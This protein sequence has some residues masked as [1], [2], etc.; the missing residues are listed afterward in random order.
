M[1][2]LKPVA[3]LLAA[4]AIG[5][6]GYEKLM[7]AGRM[8]ISGTAISCRQRQV[9]DVLAKAGD[10]IWRV[11]IGGEEYENG[12]RV[13]GV[14]EHGVVFDMYAL[15]SSGMK[16]EFFRVNFDG[17]VEYRP[18]TLDGIRVEKTPAQG[19]AKVTID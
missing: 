17:K 11:N 3:L 19:I 12:I 1:R 18:S 5:F 2:S 4:G 9:C 16:S 8:E 15:G 6:C 13:V 14:D 10:I 7:P